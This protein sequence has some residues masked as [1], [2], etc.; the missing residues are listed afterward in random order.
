VGQACP[1]P[2]GSM[3]PVANNGA[4]RDTTTAGQA[5]LADDLGDSRGQHNNSWSLK[6]PR[7]DPLPDE[8]SRLF[9]EQSALAAK[10]RRDADSN[11]RHDH[12]DE[13]PQRHRGA[14]LRTDSTEHDDRGGDE[15]VHEPDISGQ[16]PF[17]WPIGSR[18]RIRGLASPARTPGLAFRRT[19]TFP[20]LPR[21]G[22]R[23]R[24]SWCAGR[25]Q[26]HELAT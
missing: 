14:R 25:A 9:E 17:R 13:R 6:R 7:R 12:E 5:R 16:P 24:G 3:A 2:S 10:R 26:G 22:G 1:V 11:D 19:G 21:S 20:M 23:M 4:G 18:D 8:T 15:R